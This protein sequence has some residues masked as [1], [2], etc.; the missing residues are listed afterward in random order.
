MKKY[1]SQFGDIKRLRLSRNKKTGASK[2]Y[3]FIEFRHGEVADIA[4]QA[5]NN[6]LMFGHILQCRVIPSEKV[7]EELFKGSNERF[8]VDPRNKKAG[9]EMERGAS[10]AD[11]ET[12]VQN[13]NKRRTRNAK[14]LQDEFGYSFTAP[15]VKTV[16]AVP[17]KALAAEDEAEQQLL[18]EAPAAET[19][20]VVQVT[21]STPDQLTITE[22]VKVKKT[23]KKAKSEV[24]PEPEATAVAEPEAAPTPKAKKEKKRKSDV[25]AE[26]V[27][28]AVSTPKNKKAKK[29]TATEGEVQSDKKR[30][31]KV[32]DQDGVK[33]KKAKRHSMG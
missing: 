22:T 7:H 15:T 2:H 6:Y 9:N 30:K 33:P 29:D 14:A 10:R 5:M 8:K 23:K 24:K 18:D 27:E 1:F 32:A 11:W 4:A 16:D 21:E 12:R 25:G 3:A 26:Q 19:T 31:T 17:K 13:E 28:E 20:T